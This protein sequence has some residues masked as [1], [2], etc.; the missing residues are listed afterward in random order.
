MQ[1]K[2]GEFIPTEPGSQVTVTHGAQ[3]S[4]R[5]DGKN[6]ISNSVTINIVDLFESIQVQKNQRDALSQPRY[7]CDFG[8]LTNIPKDLFPI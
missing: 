3:Q 4:L 1:C 5:H 2:D 8:I 6:L 7:D